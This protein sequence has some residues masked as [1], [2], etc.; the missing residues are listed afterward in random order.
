MLV[1]DP[2]PVDPAFKEVLKQG[3]ALPS[4]H[5]VAFQTLDSWERL[6]RAGMQTVSHSELFLCGVLSA[7]SQPPS[8][9]RQREVTKYLQVMAT[10]QSHTLDILTRL[11]AG[12]TLVR[13]DAYLARSLLDDTVRSS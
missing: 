2:P 10:A 3:V 13:R 7:L 8:E 11:A 5:S 12:P 1:S 4:S 9:E 6:A